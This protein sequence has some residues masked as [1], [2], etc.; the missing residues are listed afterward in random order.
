V[1]RAAC[2]TF[3]RAHCTHVTYSLLR[4]RDGRAPTP[5]EAEILISDESERELYLLCLDRHDALDKPPDH[6][7]REAFVQM[8]LEHGLQARGGGVVCSSRSMK[9]AVNKQALP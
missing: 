2:D 3:L 4:G 1:R 9:S 8:A 5:E 6:I 7:C